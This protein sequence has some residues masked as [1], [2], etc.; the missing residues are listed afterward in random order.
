MRETRSATLFPEVGMQFIL[1]VLAWCL[2][3]A[4]AWPLALIVVIL[5]PLIWLVALPF[6]ILGWGIGGALALI[7]SLL[8][9]PARLLGYKG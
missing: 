8:Y 1:V 5:L 2:L 3:A 7:K 6:R 4:V 9:L